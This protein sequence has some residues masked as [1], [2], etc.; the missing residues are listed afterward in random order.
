MALFHV[1]RRRFIAQAFFD[2]FKFVTIGG[3]LS[4]F[5]KDLGP[6]MKVGVVTTALTSLVI[7]FAFCPEKEEDD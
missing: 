2:I 3:C 6:T 4:G 1:Q 5:F 7:G